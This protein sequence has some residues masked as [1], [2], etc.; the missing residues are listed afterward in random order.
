MRWRGSARSTRPIETSLLAL[1]DHAGR[2]LLEGAELTG[3]T[4]ERWAQTERVDHPAV[5]VLRR[6][7][8]RA[9]RRPGAAGPAPLAHAGATCAELTDLLRGDGV[10]VAG[11]RPARGRPRR[12][13][14]RLTERFTLERAGRADE[15]PVRAGRWTWSSPRTPCGRRC[16]PGSTCSPP[17]CAAP[18]RWRT[19]S[20][21]GPGSTPSG[22]DLESITEE[23]TAL[24]ARGDLRPAGLLGA[25]RRQF[26][27]RR[28]TSR[29]HALR[30]GGAARWRTYAARSR[31]SCTSGR[32]PS[33]G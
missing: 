20:G 29:H 10:T 33:S 12:G 1:Q 15:R 19:P 25:A 18:A 4:K 30:P 26:R 24:R 3:V 31:R 22:D 6:L 7:R 23:L 17:S 11:A 9:R 14:A 5:G 21:C 2:R 28:R 32:T 8:R 13:P 27:A 16:P